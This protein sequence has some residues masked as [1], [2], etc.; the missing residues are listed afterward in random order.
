MQ[1][2]LRHSIIVCKQSM[3]REGEAPQIGLATAN[4]HDM[5]SYN[6]Q[7]RRLKEL[8]NVNHGSK[9]GEKIE[10]NNHKQ[11]QK[12]RRKKKKGKEN[13]EQEKKKVF[14]FIQTNRLAGAVGADNERERAIEINDCTLVWAV[15]SYAL[16]HHFVNRRHG[17][18]GGE[19]SRQAGFFLASSYAEK[20]EMR[21]KTSKEVSGE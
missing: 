20:H 8:V 2:C 7:S 4:T 21:R 13:E 15:A 5:E 14:L 17:G 11:E 19:E 9:R 12:K 10:Q 6:C 16:D 1:A 18:Q 3:F